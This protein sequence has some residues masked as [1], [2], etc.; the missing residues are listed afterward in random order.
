M[1][2]DPQKNYYDILGVSEDAN[3]DEIKKAFRKAAVKHHPDRGWDVEKFQAMNEA[4]QIL[5][6]QQKRQQYDMF[7]KG[8]MWGFGWGWM[9]WFGWG[10]GGWVDLWDLVWDLFGWG[11]GWW[12]R[13]SKVRKGNDIQIDVTITFEESFHGIDKNLEYSRKIRPDNVTSE[14]CQTCW[15]AGKVAQQAQT[16]FGVMQVQSACPTCSGL[17][18]IYKKDGVTIANG[19]LEKNK[20]VIGVKIPAGIKDWVFIKFEWKG[21]EWIGGGPVW[22]L[23]I[24][25]SIK[26]SNKYERKGADIYIKSEVSMFD[27]VL[28]WEIKVDHPDGKKTIKIPKGTQ[29][30]DKIRVKKAWFWDKWIFST[31]WDLYITPQL[32]IPKRLS[33]EQEKLWNKLKETS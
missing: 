12:G 20:E 30:W 19:W 8:W 10:F 4:H 16:P 3:D 33:K 32:S 5:S 25:I 13:Q 14:K 22:N 7:R 24:K 9:W 29:I 21:D 15:W 27:L 17:G 31:A 11:F 28:G 1:D 2:F 23:Y 26:H 6:D 18:E